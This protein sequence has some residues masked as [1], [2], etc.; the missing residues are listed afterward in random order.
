MGALIYTEFQVGI[1]AGKNINSNQPAEIYTDQ[2]TLT[3][4]SIEFISSAIFQGLDG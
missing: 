4:D 3:L 2:G 1:Q